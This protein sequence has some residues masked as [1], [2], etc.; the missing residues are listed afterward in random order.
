[1]L[2]GAQYP[3]ILADGVGRHPEALPPLRELAE[4]LHGAGRLDGGFN[5]RRRRHPLNASDSRQ[6]VSVRPTSCWRW[7][8]S[9]WSAPSARVR[10][11]NDRGDYPST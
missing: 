5:H 6:E 2:A 9:T 8:C 7:T 3:V 4:L 1:M 11:I 10:R